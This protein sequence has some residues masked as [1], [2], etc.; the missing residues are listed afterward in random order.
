MQG[1]SQ[2]LLLPRRSRRSVGMQDSGLSETSHFPKG[3]SP[4]LLSA[5]SLAAAE[6]RPIGPEPESVVAT[7]YE[8]ARMLPSCQA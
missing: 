2:G 6:V 8:Q 3:L 5:A 7:Y 4:V 1:L